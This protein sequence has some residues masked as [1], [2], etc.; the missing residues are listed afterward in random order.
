MRSR[1]HFLSLLVLVCC[2]TGC[3]RVPDWFQ[4]TWE[5]D[6]KAT[7]DAALKRDGN[8][9]AV[10]DADGNPKG[11]QQPVNNLLD[12][13][14]RGIGEALAPALLAS[15]YDKATVTI[16]SNTFTVMKNGNG[17]ELTFKLLERTPESVT[18]KTSDDRILTWYK[19][20]AMIA[21]HSTQD[22]K[23]DLLFKRLK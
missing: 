19:R 20:D 22:A 4:G 12:T 23:L 3:S 16:T 17:R 1:L 14:A 8:T 2:L 10:R 13:L 18:I 11:P 6:A 7:V 15:E 21:T 9:Q 5:L